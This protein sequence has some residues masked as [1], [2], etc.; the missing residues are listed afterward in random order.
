MRVSTE[1][2]AE[3]GISLEGQRVKL[4]AFAV[5]S[6][7]EL[8]AV[9]ED[10][11]VS[12]KSLARAGLQAA[13]ED[14]RCGRADAL[15]VT[16]L[17]RLTRSVHD[18]GVLLGRYFETRFTLLSIADS[19]D[20]R[21]AS[22]RLVLNVLTSVAQWEREAIGERTRDVLRHLKAKGVRI[23]G[24]ALGWKR[25]AARDAEGRQLW[26]ADLD[27]QTTARRIHELRSTGASLRAICAALEREGRMTKRGGKWAPQTIRQVLQR[28]A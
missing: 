26:I 1:S 9:R 28:V 23:G 22:G 8:V 25:V 2:Q 16:K 12:A 6:E 11:G 13:L 10:A 21:T 3:E 17:D 18:L 7:L 5:A 4:E 20:T 27:E 15:V 14:L 19:V 24:E